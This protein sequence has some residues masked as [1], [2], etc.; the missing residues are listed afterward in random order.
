MPGC[1]HWLLPTITS[2]GCSQC[3]LC[4]LVFGLPL[5]A[6]YL[7]YPWQLWSGSWLTPWGV[8]ALGPIS[9]GGGQ[10]SSAHFSPIFPEGEVRATLLFPP[11][12]MLFSVGREGEGG[13]DGQPSP[14]GEEW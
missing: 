13:P 7:G 6:M 5:T 11:L 10:F 12:S 1:Q 8:A 2:T 3:W 14:R 4:R 9:L